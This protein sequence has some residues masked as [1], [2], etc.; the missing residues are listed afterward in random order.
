M[1][2]IIAVTVHVYTRI[3]YQLFILFHFTEINL[4]DDFDISETMDNIVETEGLQY[5]GR[6]FTFSD[7]KQN[8]MKKGD[9]ASEIAKQAKV[10]AGFSV[11]ANVKIDNNQECALLWIESI[12]ST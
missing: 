9:L 6:A 12:Y 8:L 4:L 10:Y 2:L 5:E 11:T 3:L 1:I 7:V